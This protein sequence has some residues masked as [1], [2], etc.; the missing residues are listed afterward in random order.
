MS[1]KLCLTRDEIKAL[2]RR[3]TKACQLRF[4]R[5][6]DIRHYIDCH[7]WPVVLRAAVGEEV[8][9]DAPKVAPGRSNKALPPLGG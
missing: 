3:A 5:Q 4:L 2:T 7:G 6:N 1:D 9:A 8:R